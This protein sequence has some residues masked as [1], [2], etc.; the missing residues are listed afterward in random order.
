MIQ[1]TSHTKWTVSEDEELFEEDISTVVQVALPD[2]A[3][4]DEL[5]K[6]K[7]QD[8]E[9]KELKSAIARG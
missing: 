1:D 2:A 5:L 9:L 4:W 8:P 7:S 3:S 6:E